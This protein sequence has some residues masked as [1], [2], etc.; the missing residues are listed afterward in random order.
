M[1]DLQIITLFTHT[2]HEFDT[3]FMLP[4]YSAWLWKKITPFMRILGWAWYT[5]LSFECPTHRC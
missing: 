5:L 1:A 4:M 2:S 3:L